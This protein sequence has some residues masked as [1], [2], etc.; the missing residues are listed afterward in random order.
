MPPA[1]PWQEATFIPVR[2][3]SLPTP[4]DLT[5]S[6]AAPPQ[7]RLST[8]WIVGLIA[9]AV[10]FVGGGILTGVLLAKDE[11][12]PRDRAS[13]GAQGSPDGAPSPPAAET[14]GAADT[15]TTPAAPSAAPDPPAVPVAIQDN[16]GETQKGNSGQRVRSSA[17]IKQVRFVPAAPAGPGWVFVDFYG[18]SSP[19]V[20]VIVRVDVDGDRRPEFVTWRHLSTGAS[21][22]GPVRS[23]GHGRDTI[24]GSQQDDAR[25]QS[26]GYVAPG[27]GVSFPIDLAAAEIPAGTVRVN[28]Q[29]IS[30]ASYY[31]YA[32][33]RQVWSDPIVFRSA[34]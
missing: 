33:H 10:V 16:Q 28:V 31:D 32:P 34:S 15:A 6:P 5:K 20:A 14:P 25:F 24:K 18:Q 27:G 21:G 11:A 8:P 23:W 3:P 13:A 26:A 22:S 9:A 30:D 29:V 4:V 2:S 7:R 19:A 12:G 17:D 1:D